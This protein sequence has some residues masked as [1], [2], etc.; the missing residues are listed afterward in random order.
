M[1]S[2]YEQPKL[3]TSKQYNVSQ[4]NIGQVKQYTTDWSDYE[5]AKIWEE[6]AKGTGKVNESIQESAKLRG[7]LD[8][9][10]NL[11]AQN[12]WLT[13]DSYNQGRA[14]VIAEQQK[15]KF[16]EIVDR[17][18]REVAQKNGTMEDY[19]KAIEPYYQEYIKNIRNVAT[20]DV[21][22]NPLSIELQNETLVNARKEMITYVALGQ[23]KFQKIK[24]AQNEVDRQELNANVGGNLLAAIQVAPNA[25]DLIPKIMNTYEQLNLIG[26]RLGDPTKAK[27]EADGITSETLTKSIGL[28]E[29]TDPLSTEK[30]NAIVGLVNSPGFTMHPIAKAKVLE[31]ADKFE[32]E[33]YG[34]IEYNISGSIDQ[35]EMAAATGN[36]KPGMQ[37]AIAK[38]IE[39]G[40][41]SGDLTFAQGKALNTRLSNLNEKI[42]KSAMSSSESVLSMNAIAA[43][44]DPEHP[45]KVYNA[46][47]EAES[48]LPGASVTSGRQK[49]IKHISSNYMADN[50]EYAY[51]LL[52]QYGAEFKYHFPADSNTPI[53]EHVQWLTANG[54][55]KLLTQW[56]DMVQ[57]AAQ[58]KTGAG[59]AIAG[60]LPEAYKQP[61]LQNVNRLTGNFADDMAILQQ[62]RLEIEQNER[63]G[64]KMYVATADDFKAGFTSFFGNK[65]E[66]DLNWLNSAGE[67]TRGYMSQLSNYS[68]GIGTNRGAAI[69]TGITDFSSRDS[70]IA[71]L[72]DTGLFYSTGAHGV[73]SDVP[74]FE[75]VM[76]NGKGSIT[77]NDINTF[78]NE[79]ASQ[80]RT[81]NPNLP[82]APW[83]DNDMVF[84]FDGL[85]LTA[86][87]I[88]KNTGR[89][90]PLPN[91]RS[92][93]PISE[94]HTKFKELDTVRFA[95]SVVPKKL[96]GSTVSPNLQALT[97]VFNNSAAVS[98]FMGMVAQREGEVFVPTATDPKRPHI[99][100]IGMGVYIDKHPVEAAMI[101]E[102]YRTGNKELV[103][104]GHTEVMAKLMKQS[105]PALNSV[106]GSKD[107]STL[108]FNERAAATL[109]LDAGWW[110]GGGG[111]NRVAKAIK[112]AQSTGN[113]DRAMS[114]SGLNKV[115]ELYTGYK[116]TRE[117]DGKQVAGKLNGRGKDIL[118]M[119]KA[120]AREI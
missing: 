10:G 65:I 20:V 114:E 30:V 92:S 59:T 97:N 1:A 18:S 100:T 12:S 69:K 2:N 42:A 98:N 27:A 24:E 96:T 44:T 119:L 73:I 7:M 61:F 81:R 83:T 88:D 120:Y 76:K 36:Y 5:S 52:R 68:M 85:S 93:I 11:V 46:I 38:S 47:M 118:Y 16:L 6:V 28:L 87:A 77:N 90:I 3:A 115:G 64:L 75:Q 62:S 26:A 25:A 84:H 57:L 39:A 110:G 17:T 107:V 95:K 74:N 71:A 103:N 35:L 105:L 116:V 55:D 48:K 40:V 21:N 104:K 19:N 53:P 60:E 112:I 99:K 51:Y 54:K 108:G 106:F 8:Q 66:Q 31:A 80:L 13:D 78:I 50:P 63:S 15:G 67:G 43:S 86:T 111:A 33:V 82:N 29:P 72:T 22:G 91:G 9:T 89:R 109:I 23:Q 101:M 117:V 4:G 58:T 14:A 34:A 113:A 79:I 41:R 32:R 45:K 49:Y 37:A 70:F 102:G 94:I 56:P